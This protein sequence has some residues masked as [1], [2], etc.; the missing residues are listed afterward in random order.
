V[1]YAL[2]DVKGKSMKVL[3]PRMLIAETFSQRYLRRQFPQE[4]DYWFVWDCGPNDRRGSGFYQIS[5]SDRRGLPKGQREIYY[6]DHVADYPQFDLEVAIGSH[7]RSPRRPGVNPQLPGNVEAVI[8]QHV[9]YYPGADNE[10]EDANLFSVRTRSASDIKAAL[11]RLTGIEDV[12]AFAEGIGGQQVTILDLHD[13]VV[14][15]IADNGLADGLLNGCLR[16]TV[17]LRYRLRLY[18]V[19]ARAAKELTRE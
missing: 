15:F 4:G 3:K 19:T 2:Y 17:P 12:N 7:K 9:Q 8:R 10:S 14:D 18:R 13:A 11:R 5:V 6:T 1:F 16:A